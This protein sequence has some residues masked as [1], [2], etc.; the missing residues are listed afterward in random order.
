MAG[1]IDRKMD[2]WMDRWMEQ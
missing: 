2:S 1:W